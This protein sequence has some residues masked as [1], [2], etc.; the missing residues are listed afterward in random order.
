LLDFVDPPPTPPEAPEVTKARAEARHW[1]NGNPTVRRKVEKKLADRGDDASYILFTAIEN[2][3]SQIDAIDKR[4]AAHEMRRM[5][6]LKEIELWNGILAR[7]LEL[8]SSEVIEGEF[9]EAA[10]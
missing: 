9:T 8:A 1:T 2:S 4:I 6:A 7:R 3:H 5:A 10:E